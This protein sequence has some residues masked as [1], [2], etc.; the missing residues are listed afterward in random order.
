MHLLPREELKL[1]L[2]LAGSLAQKRLARGVKLNIVEATALIATVLQEL[3]RDGHHSVAELMSLGK[4]LLGRRQVLPTVPSQLHDIQVEGTFP[5]GTF[6]VTVHEPISRKDGDLELALYGSFYPIPGLDKFGTEEDI[7]EEVPGQLVVCK[8]SSAIK[9]NVG[10][11]RVKLKVT[12]NGDRP[13]QVGSHYHFAETNKQLSFDRGLALGK[14]L[15]IAAGTAVR[16]EPGEGKTVTLVAIG[17]HQRVSGGNG[18]Y[19]AA[20]AEGEAFMSMKQLRDLDSA[21]DTFVRKVVE[22]GFS[23]SPA[24]NALVS[25]KDVAPFEL[26]REGYCALYGP[27]TGDRIRLGDSPLWIEVEKD[28]TSYG[29]ECKFGGG[30]VLREGMGQATGRPDAETLDLVILNALIVDWSG[31]YKADIGVKNGFIVGIGKSGNPDVMDGVTEGMVIGANTEAIE[32]AGSIVTAGALD[33][34]VHFI[35]PQLWP[36]ALASGITTLVGGGTGPSAGTSATTCTPG[37]TYIQMLLTALDEVPMN[38]GK[39][40]CHHNTTSA[41]SIKANFGISQ[42]LRAKATTPAAKVWSTKSKRASRV[43]SC[44][45]TGGRLPPPSIPACPSPTSSTSRQTSTPTRST[46]PPS[47]RTR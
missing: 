37:K 13:V 5:D 14:R 29:D 23:H 39:A 41:L 7:K 33:A 15:D 28:L 18:L 42:S 8:T 31:I 43:S 20:F 22:L 44:T 19:K 27:T 26:S 12:N 1:Q 45:K 16:F 32:A 46:S 36:E 17:G 11:E 40:H 25:S 30:K 6:L 4:T 3:I 34:H 47:A 24:G 38:T 9:L 35:C 2:H 10:R 21:R